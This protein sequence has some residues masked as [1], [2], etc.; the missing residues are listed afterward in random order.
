MLGHIWALAGSGTSTRCGALREF[1]PGAL[2][3][4]GAQLAE[5]EAL[6]VL[7]L[8]PTPEQG[9]RLTRAAIRRAL[10]QAGR[11]RNLQTRVVAAVHDALAAP[12][13]AASAP[14]EAAYREVVAALVAMLRWLNEQVAALEQQL[15]ARFA[16]N[17]DAVI[18]RSLPG[19]GMVLG[20]RVLGE[21]GDDPARYQTAKGRKAFA[22]TAPITRSSGLR[23]RWWLPAPSVT[24]GWWMP[25]TCG[26]SPR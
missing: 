2:A 13:L 11:R 23:I 17:P 14:I 24:S 20:A 3:A 16:A 5:R 15:A 25:A 7:E 12:Q 1:Y 9:R 8:A 18:L 6:A 4:L 21:F 19:L 26:H 10:V 22:G